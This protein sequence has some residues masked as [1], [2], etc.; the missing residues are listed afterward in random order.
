MKEGDFITKEEFLNEIAGNIFSHDFNVY[1]T[2][3][4]SC[5]QLME[6]LQEYAEKTGLFR[7]FPVNAKNVTL[8]KS[9]SCFVEGFMTEQGFP[10]PKYGKD[11]FRYAIAKIRRE[12]KNTSM[13]KA[14]FAVYNIHRA[15]DDLISKIERL[16]N[17]LNYDCGC[18]ISTVFLGTKTQSARF[19]GN[20]N[21]KVKPLVYF[22]LDDELDKTEESEVY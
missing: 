16:N 21:D 12:S 11:M 2:E 1:L 4:D 8:D 14:V 3:K 20:L 9:W 7:V 13:K 6:T 15:D 5:F 18:S 19:L 17:T 22:H 10:V